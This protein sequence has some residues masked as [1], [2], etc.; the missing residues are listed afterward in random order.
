MTR[1]QWQV[2]VVGA[3]LAAQLVAFLVYR[4]KAT[5]GADTVAPVFERF[6]PPRPLPRLEVEG[7]S[8]ERHLVRPAGRPLLLH[9]WASWC[10]PCVDELPAL[11]GAADRGSLGA[12]VVAVSV[13]ESWQVMERVVDALHPLLARLPHQEAKALFEL[14]PLPQTYVVDGRGLVVGR[15]RGAQAWGSPA[16]G[17]ALQDALRAS[18]AEVVR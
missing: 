7:R 4:A 14:G 3:A 15:F 16:L 18:H 5:P 9:F 1:R 8:G 2:L 12:E 13:D 6:D 17:A 10:A 11:L